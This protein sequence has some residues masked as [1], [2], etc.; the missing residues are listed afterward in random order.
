MLFSSCKKNKD[1]D[2]IIIL[3]TTTPDKECY[4]SNET[5]VFEIESFANKG[6]VG[7]IN[8]TSV[9]SYGINII[10]DTIIN[11]NRTDFYYLYKVPVFA[12]SLQSVKLIFTGVC[13]TGNSSKMTKMFS[14]ISEDIP[15]EEHGQF[16]MYSNCSSNK[17]GFSIELEQT[18]FSVIDSVYCDIYDNTEAGSAVLSKEW[19]SKTGVLFARFNDFNYESAT[20][21]S[22]MN[23]YENANKT[24][25]MSNISN[26][27]I[28]F[29][30]RGNTALGVIKVMAVYD[31]EG[32]ETDRYN[33]YLKKL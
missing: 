5:I 1:E 3:V 27:D 10:F 17:N 13:S 14:V 12:D 25:I 11:N 4:N 23:A 15:L 32:Y 16:T 19:H 20:R 8:V 28:I 7:S 30:G 21:S 6:C 31:D 26:D 9:S 24:S 29:V 18:V 22:V 2:D 33:F